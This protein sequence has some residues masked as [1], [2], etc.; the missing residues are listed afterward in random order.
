MSAA[1]WWKAAAAA[2]GSLASPTDSSS[3]NAPQKSVAAAPAAAGV[4]DVSCGELGDAEEAE[5]LAAA[6][7]AADAIL[8]AR[9]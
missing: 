6:E 1:A 3:L 8:D 5:A 4:E 7:D 9:D 2:A